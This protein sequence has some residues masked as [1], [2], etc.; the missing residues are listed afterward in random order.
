MTFWERLGAIFGILVLPLVPACL[1]YYLFGNSSAASTW[2]EFFTLGGPIAAY[3]VI[4]CTAFGIFRN[5]S[6]P[7]ETSKLKLRTRMHKLL[8]GQWTCESKVHSAEGDRDVSG[9]A[10]ISVASDGEISISGHWFNQNNEPTGVWSADEIILTE[11]K[12][13]VVYSVPTVTGARGAFIGLI[14]LNFVYANAS[15]T[16]AQLKGYWG[17]LGQNIY[18][19]TAWDRTNN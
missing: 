8:I 5:I 18:G 16:V 13:V 6:T 19:T 9:C 17:V 15:H 7:E 10:V 1:I 11:R 4:M 2:G 12:L 3:F 14:N